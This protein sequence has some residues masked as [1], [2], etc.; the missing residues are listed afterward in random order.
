MC[1]LSREEFLELLKNSNFLSYI[2]QDIVS[3]IQDFINNHFQYYEE[4]IDPQIFLSQFFDILKYTDKLET[5]ILLENIRSCFL[6]E[7]Q[8]YSF[9]LKPHIQLLL[10]DSI[11]NISDFIQLTKIIPSNELGNFL[12]SSNMEGAFIQ[13]LFE[14]GTTLE[15]TQLLEVLSTNYPG[16]NR[17]QA[18][19]WLKRIDSAYDNA[20]SLKQRRPGLNIKPLPPPSKISKDDR[21]FRETT[22]RMNK[23][24][25]RK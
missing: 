8:Q 19:E 22:A 23:L 12:K 13:Q 6:T 24:L 20:I 4:I 14:C 17:L 18:H 1:D 21:P 3:E 7:D 2:N 10:N 9:L 25:N 15:K 11:K 5:S 16:F